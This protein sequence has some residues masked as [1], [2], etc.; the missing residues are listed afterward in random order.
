MNNVMA[1]NGMIAVRLT[2]RELKLLN[3]AVKRVCEIY[4]L[5]GISK[6][7]IVRYAIRALSHLDEEDFKTFLKYMGEVKLSCNK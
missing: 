1:K 4:W 6:S 5:T 3:K 2:N 7:D